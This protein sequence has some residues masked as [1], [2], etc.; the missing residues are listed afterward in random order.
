[1]VL[2]LVH[3]SRKLP[4]P[5]WILP[6]I[7]TCNSSSGSAL[8]KVYPG[9]APHPWFY[10]PAKFMKLSWADSHTG[11]RPTEGKSF[12]TKMDQEKVIRH[13]KKGLSHKHKRRVTRGSLHNCWNIYRR[14]PLCDVHRGTGNFNNQSRVSSDQPVKHRRTVRTGTKAKK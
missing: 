6:I 10:L 12:N 11:N 8:S 5:S 13:R 7:C 1:M 9:A 2:D 3:A 14:C 4:N